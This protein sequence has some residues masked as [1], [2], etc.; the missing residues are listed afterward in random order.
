[1]PFT[2][3]QKDRVISAVSAKAPT[4]GACPVCAH[5]EWTLADG[6]IF[7]AIQEPSGPVVLGGPSMPC[8]ALVC[9]NCGNTVLL[10]VMTLGLRDML[11]SS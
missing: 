1:M 6:F 3:D 7:L 10:N 9:N 2:H 5:P 8:V 11:D 4:L